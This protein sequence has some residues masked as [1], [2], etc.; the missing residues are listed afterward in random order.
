MQTLQST[1]NL[2]FQ[3]I[4]HF[5]YTGQALPCHWRYTVNQKA[6][7][8]QTHG[9]V[10]EIDMEMCHYNTMRPEGKFCLGV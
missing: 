3:F 6:L 1:N 2:V 10:K 4:E 5:L 8:L 9:P 7:P